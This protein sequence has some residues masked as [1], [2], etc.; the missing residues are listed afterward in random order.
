MNRTDVA[1]ALTRKWARASGVK[2]SVI[3]LRSWSF[4]MFLSGLYLDQ[5]GDD[6]ERRTGVM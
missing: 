3:K 2:I 6:I 1:W 5:W 4:A